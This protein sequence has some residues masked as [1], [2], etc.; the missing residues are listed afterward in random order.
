MTFLSPSF[1]AFFAGILLM[2]WK[3]KK[4]K[5]KVKSMEMVRIFSVKVYHIIIFLFFKTF[6]KVIFDTSASARFTSNALT[7]SSVKDNDVNM[8]NNEFKNFCEDLSSKLFGN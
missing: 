1:Y 4:E 3:I 8:N 7:K 5:L 6:S 2:L